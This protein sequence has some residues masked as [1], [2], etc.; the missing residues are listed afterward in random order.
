MGDKESQ[1][2]MSE[3]NGTMKISVPLDKWVEDVAAR[4]AE[5][6]LD[7][8]YAGCIIHDVEKDVEKL[9]LRWAF[10][11]GICFASGLGGGIFGAWLRT[12]I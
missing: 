9:K 2:K 8:H 11:A 1:V 3:V 10:L 5:K 7:R 4:A 6:A 12:L